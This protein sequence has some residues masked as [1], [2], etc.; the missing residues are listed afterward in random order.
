MSETLTAR[1]PPCP[2]C[3]T[4]SLSDGI[5]PGWGEWRRCPRC[6]HVFAD[7]LPTP[8]EMDTLLNAAYSGTEDRTGM[9]DFAGRLKQR[10]ALLGD[11]S[12][13]YWTPAYRRVLEWLAERFPPGA[14]VL[15]IGPGPGFF[16]HAIK[17]AGFRAVGVELAR[18]AVDLNRRDGFDVWHGP[19]ESI[20]GG[21]VNADA[22]VAF[23]MLHHVVDPSGFLKDIRDRWPNAPL[24]I[25][26]Y[27]PSNLD[28]VR[29]LP[30]R[31]LHRW[32]GRALT[33]ALERAGYSPTVIEL[34][35]TG[36]ELDVLKPL[37]GLSRTV[38]GMP[39][40]YRLVTRAI[41]R[42]LPRLLGRFQREAYVLLAFAEPETFRAGD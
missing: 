14:V 10:E 40:L 21:W 26:Q 19:V 39:W 16:L 1:E 41:V 3:G 13:W 33:V 18:P 32:N 17:A 29:S 34:P 12:L 37:R 28:P 8:D 22:I 4:S 20:P 23:F 42:L 11:P 15:E 2:V 31:M 30:P 25:G 35:S 24:A 7:P 6:T 5:V 36:V 27:G 9:A 38:L